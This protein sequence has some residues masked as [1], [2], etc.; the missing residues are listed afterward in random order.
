MVKKDTWKSK[1]NLKNASKLVKEF[2]KEYRRA[3][4]EEA[5]Q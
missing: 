4:E 2:E 1:E 3:E 5:R